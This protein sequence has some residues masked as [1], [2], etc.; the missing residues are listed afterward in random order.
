[1]RK[2]G[3]QVNGLGTSDG[4]SSQ[5]TSD[6]DSQTKRS[7]RTRAVSKAADTKGTKKKVAAAGSGLNVSICHNAI[8]HICT[9]NMD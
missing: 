2:A 8:R 6:E 7:Q 9:D 5:S 1:M 3:R 4:E